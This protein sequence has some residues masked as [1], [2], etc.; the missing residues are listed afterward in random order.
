MNI[1]KPKIKIGHNLRVPKRKKT[2]L[3]PLEVRKKNLSKLHGTVKTRKKLQK[4]NKNKSHNKKNSL[5]IE[6]IKMQKQI[7]QKDSEELKKN[8]KKLQTLIISFS[9]LEQLSEKSIKNI[10]E[11]RL[12]ICAENQD[13][14]KRINHSVKKLAG[15][16][17]KYKNTS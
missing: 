16:E 10:Q 4:T 15:Y 7:Q 5:L 2:K 11:R 1:K 17:S 3:N 8:I 13:V 9:G 6:K 12:K 14:V